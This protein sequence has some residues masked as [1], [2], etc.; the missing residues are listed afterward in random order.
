MG[1]KKTN[2]GIYL[3]PHDIL[4]S[5]RC[6]SLTPG[7]AGI[8]F[9][10]FL[11]LCDPPIPGA[12]RLRDWEPHPKWQKS[13]TR[14]CLGIADKRERLP[15]FAK[16]LA[17][18][19]LPWTKNEVLPYLQ[20]LYDR[21]IIIVEGDMLIQPRL[22][23]DNGFDI[24]DID[25]DGDPVG[26]I[27][28]DPVSG[29]MRAYDNTLQGGLNIRKNRGAENGTINDTEKGTKKGTKNHRVGTGDAQAHSK[30]V[31]VGDNNIVNGN[32]GGAGG[33]TPDKPKTQENTLKDKNRASGGE[34]KSM[35]VNVLSD[36]QKP[37]SG[38]ENGVNDNSKG[39]PVA[40]CPPTL[41]EIQRYMQEQGEMG[42][43]F[44][45]I[46]ADQFYDEG[47]M[48]GW[49]IRGGQPLYDWKA[50]LRSLE[51]YR[52]SHGDRPATDK[53]FVSYQQGQPKAGDPVAATPAA[54][55]KYKNKW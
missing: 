47:C 33:N 20:E 8:Y 2:P 46:T 22:Y 34:K 27:L 48:N 6:R 32:I 29:Q 42:K 37:V 9:F 55:G 51:A 30:R 18:N 24:P 25:G 36:E 23:V 5:P 12:Y 14:K 11:R 41:G 28:D 45:F 38:H 16:W 49:Q 7:G 31:G 50:R 52:R 10:L 17:K 26:S 44:R 39:T 54:K 35:V 40:D 53:G 13:D 3:Y 4:S 15:L 1:R 43:P 19:D 21:G